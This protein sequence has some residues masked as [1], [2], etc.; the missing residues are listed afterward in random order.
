M[1]ESCLSSF[2]KLAGVGLL[3]ELSSIVT[4]CFFF[5][6]WLVVND[7]SFVGGPAS[8]GDRGSFGRGPQ[9]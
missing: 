6:R 4:G 1:G 7:L 9:W 5:C 2:L 8:A 3:E